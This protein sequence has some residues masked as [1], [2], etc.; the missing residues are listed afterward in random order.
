MILAVPPNSETA[1]FDGGEA[2]PDGLAQGGRIDVRNAILVTDP[3]VGHVKPLTRYVAV[4]IR[5]IVGVEPEAR[6]ERNLMRDG[7]DAPGLHKDLLSAVGGAS[8]GG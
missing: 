2:E 8:G 7:K 3:A 6:S 5:R 1:S 4:R